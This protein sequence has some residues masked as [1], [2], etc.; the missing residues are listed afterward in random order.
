MISNRDMSR[1]FA[2]YAELLLLHKNERLQ[3]C[4]PVLHTV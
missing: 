2:L 4:F 3:L 1:L